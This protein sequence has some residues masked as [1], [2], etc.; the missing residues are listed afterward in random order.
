MFVLEFVNEEERMRTGY[1]E[2]KV[3]NEGGEGNREWERS[4]EGE[5]DGEEKIG[6]EGEGEM[7]GGGKKGIGRKRREMGRGRDVK[8]E[9]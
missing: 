9:K 4:M 1:R 6:V 7:N 5:G 2:W 3:C 8:T